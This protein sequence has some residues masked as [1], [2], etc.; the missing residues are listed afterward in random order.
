[1]SASVQQLANGTQPAGLIVFNSNNSPIAE[2]N[3]F[4]VIGTVTPGANA[5][6]VQWVLDVQNAVLPTTGYATVQYAANP[7]FEF[8]TAVQDTPGTYYAWA[9]DPL[10]NAY[11]VSPALVV[12]TVANAIAFTDYGDATVVLQEAGNGSYGSIYCDGTIAPIFRGVDYAINQSNTVAPTTGWVAMQTDGAGNWTLSS[13]STPA[14]PS[15]STLPLGNSYIW[16]R[17]HTTNLNTVSGALAVFNAITTGTAVGIP[18]Q[19]VALGTLRIPG[20]TSAAVTSAP[21]YTAVLLR[22][23]SSNTTAPTTGGDSLAVA[24]TNGDGS[25]NWT[26]SSYVG[27][28]SD[29]NI[30]TAGTYYSWFNVN[31]SG[32][33]SGQNGLATGTLTFVAPAM[34]DTAMTISAGP[35]VH[36]GTVSLAALAITTGASAPSFGWSTSTVTPPGSMTAFTTKTTG[37]PNDTWADSTAALPG[38]AGTYYLWCRNANGGYGISRLS[39]ITVT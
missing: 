30:T 18:T 6:G 38:S 21:P 7:Q 39:P 8:V 31:R 19:T 1:V 23:G 32:G 14:A 25:K 11:A 22:L 20:M 35:Y 26:R 12:Q 33:G 4:F 36:G 2:G 16:A 34:D 3:S 15:V 9:K 27:L 13:T 28:P 24:S 29:F 37:S 17:D 10:T 5:A